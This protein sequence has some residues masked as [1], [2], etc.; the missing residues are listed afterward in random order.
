LL[1]R[2]LWGEKVGERMLR[3][4]G[5][6]LRSSKHQRSDCDACRPLVSV[7]LANPRVTELQSTGSRHSYAAH[8]GRGSRNASLVDFLDGVCTRCAELAEPAAH[9]QQATPTRKASD[10]WPSGQRRQ[11]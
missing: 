9:R 7:L 3:E 2:R 10:G 5:I 8:V 11:S 6:V 1:M 4:N